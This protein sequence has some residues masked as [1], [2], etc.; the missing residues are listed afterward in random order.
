[1]FD[2]AVEVFLTKYKYIWLKNAIEQN[3]TEKEIEAKKRESNQIFTLVNWLP[4]VTKIIAR[5]NP[6]SNLDDAL[7]YSIEKCVIDEFLSIELIDGLPLLHHIKKET[8]LAKAILA[9]SGDNYHVLRKNILKING[10]LSYSEIEKN[11]ISIETTCVQSSFI[12]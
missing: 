9:V 12:F 3:M 6:S 2:L 4:Y 11:N 5:H 1:M 10:L 8:D 7:T